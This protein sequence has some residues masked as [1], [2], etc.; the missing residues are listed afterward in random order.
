MNTKRLLR[1]FLLLVGLVAC[2]ELGLYAVQSTATDSPVDHHH[3]APG[4][5]VTHSLKENDLYLNLKVTGFRFSVE[6]MGKENRNGEGHIHLYLDGKKVAKVFESQ[7]VLKDLPAG[8]HQVVVE[9][10]HNNHESYG[11]KR[12]FHVVVKP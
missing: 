5:D 2:V 3:H 11:V 12:S 10:A 6:N 4:L 8:Q 1:R 9:L 7:Y